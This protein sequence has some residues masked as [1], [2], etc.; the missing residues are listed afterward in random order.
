MAKY[1]A[2]LQSLPLTISAGVVVALLALG[3]LLWP[4]REF[5]GLEN[6]MLAQKPE[7]T[8]EGI[9]TGAFFDQSER[10]LS[11][12]FPARDAWLS[13]NAMY[14]MALLKARRNG[15]IIGKNGRL[16]EPQGN[17]AEDNIR[18]NAAALSK[19]AHAS[20][21][22]V[23]LML[24]PTAEA[25]YP[26]QLP[27]L[28]EA[29][30]QESLIHQVYERPGISGVDVLGALRGSADGGMFYRTDH[31]WTAQGAWTAYARIAFEW[32]L[33]L[34]PRDETARVPGFLGTLAARAASPFIQAEEL[35]FDLY[36]GL[37]LRVD[38]VKM[39][40]LYDP[41][42]LTERDKYAALTHGST[43]G[44]VTLEN[45]VGL[46]TLLILR[47]SYASALLPAV[48]TNFRRVVAVDPR[49]Y[50]GDLLAHIEAE[51]PERILC[52]FGISTW[53]ADRSLPA[54]ATS[55]VD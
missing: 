42:Q 29:N 28:Y 34:T 44:M 36:E 9:Q 1:K 46:G 13:V 16:F 7:L 31:H 3:T 50:N 22:P 38:G 51:Q 37:E 10:A 25:V 11:D 41:G 18:D 24:I 8:I 6:R 43:N 49:Y 15:I 40:G 12:Q 53:A 39:D 17:G 54:M 27:W 21:I 4:Q 35:T 19:L 2:W 26:G 55:W 14:D 23:W 20:G 33:A 52:V 32:G 30:D 47:D 48:A 5:S 45:P